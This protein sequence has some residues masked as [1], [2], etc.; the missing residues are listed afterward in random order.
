[1]NQNTLKINGVLFQTGDNIT[2]NINGWKITD[3]RIFIG[4]CS[5]SSIDIY[6][7]QN[8]VNG[9][10]SP[11]R[12]GYKYSYEVII[13]IYHKYYSNCNIQ[14]VNTDIFHKIIELSYPKR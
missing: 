4:G 8:Y 9:N 13:P 10:I 11:D 3:A 2:C 5:G 14:K 7:C 1:M 6:L 12:L